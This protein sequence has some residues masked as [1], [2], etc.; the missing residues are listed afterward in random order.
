MPNEHRAMRSDDAGL[1]VLSPSHDRPLRHLTEA[2]QV[3]VLFPGRAAILWCISV[4]MARVYT[5]SVPNQH[6]AACSDDTG[7]QA[8]SPSHD[9]PPLHSKEAAQVAV[10]FPGRAAILWCI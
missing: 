3:A 5:R 10:F 8:L 4:G 6:R 1:Q 7:L 9:R 2:A